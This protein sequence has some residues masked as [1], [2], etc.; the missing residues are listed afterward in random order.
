VTSQHLDVTIIKVRT[1]INLPDDVYEIA[2][3]LASSKDISLGEAPA[4]LARKGLH[5]A[6]RIDASAPFLRFSIGD[7]APPVTLETIR[8]ST[9]RSAGSTT[10]R[11]STP[12]RQ[13]TSRPRWRN[14]GG[15]PKP[16]NE[17]RLKTGQRN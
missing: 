4:G 5:P 17:G 13:G 12:S 15:H 2:R 14:L 9:T 7:D 6:P 8:R 1:T 3:S 16:A 11:G 10:V